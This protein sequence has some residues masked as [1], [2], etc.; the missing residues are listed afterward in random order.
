MACRMV[1]C[2]SE[3]RPAGVAVRGLLGDLAIRRP[4]DA[5]RDGRSCRAHLRALQCAMH[6]RRTMLG[7]A[8]HGV[9]FA[10][11]GECFM[12][13]IDINGAR[14]LAPFLTLYRASKLAEA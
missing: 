5:Q 7:R 3:T 8:E 6:L 4:R 10:Y 1:K 2:T 12:V 11:T 14:F 9:A 13:H